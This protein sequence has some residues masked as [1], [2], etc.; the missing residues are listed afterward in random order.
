LLYHT[1]IERLNISYEISNTQNIVTM[2]EAELGIIFMNL[3]QNSIYWLENI[4][5]ERKIIVQVERT[6]SEELYIVFSDS[7]PGIKEGTED[8]IFEPYFS[9][10]PDG[11]GLGLAIVGELISEYNGEFMLINNRSLDGAS[12]KI[13]FRYRI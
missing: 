6:N 5:T 2:D 9:T 13:I 12:F 7:G 1:D 3:I 4:D 11:I 8:N 10:K